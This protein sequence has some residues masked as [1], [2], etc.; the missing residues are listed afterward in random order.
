MRTSPHHVVT[1][2]AIAL[3]FTGCSARDEGAVGE[4]PLQA[5]HSGYFAVARAAPEPCAPDATCALV[6]RSLNR[7]TTR[8]ADGT[9]QV[10]CAVTDLQLA[11]LGLP[12]ALE[13]SLRA[14]MPLG[15]VLV[16]GR[17]RSAG[18]FEASEAWRGA[19][20]SPPSG[21]FYRIGDNGHRCERP[22]CPTISAFELNG[23]RQ[24]VVKDGTFDGMATAP[25]EA[26]AAQADA[27]MWTKDGFL[28]AATVA[29]AACGVPGSDCGVLVTVTELYLRVRAGEPR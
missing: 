7:P 12:P 13:A 23:A 17:L 21:T 5:F 28:A 22:V 3:A 2:L 25:D 6:V 24:H 10:A 19:T 29:P 4:D 9:E 11:G 8:C 26:S 1:V 27:A 18:R 20:G 16:K 14:E 15:R